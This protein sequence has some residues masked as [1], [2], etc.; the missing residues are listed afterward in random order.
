MGVLG[1][2]GAEKISLFFLKMVCRLTLHCCMD[3][4]DHIYSGDCIQALLP[5]SPQTNLY[6][7]GYSFQ[8]NH[9]EVQ[10][11]KCTIW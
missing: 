8:I 5:L 2:N 11:I 3:W 9:H 10:G 1:L 6:Q 7:Q 4:V